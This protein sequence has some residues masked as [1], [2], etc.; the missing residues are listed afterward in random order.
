MASIEYTS[1]ASLSGLGE[2]PSECG[3]RVTKW[4]EIDDWVENI[5]IYSIDSQ[6]AIQV[7]MDMAMKYK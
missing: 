5:I 4:A 1:G 2:S 3:Q 6:E 7:D